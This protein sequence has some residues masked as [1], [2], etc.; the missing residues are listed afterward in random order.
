MA[1][2]DESKPFAPVHY[3]EDD[4]DADDERRDKKT[5]RIDLR[6]AARSLP[7]GRPCLVMV[8]GMQSVGRVV[9]VRDGMTIGR[10]LSCDVVI[11]EQGVSRRHAKLCVAADGSVRVDDLESSNG[12]LCNG[13]K[14]VSQVVRDGDRIQLG[15]A[16]FA[17]LHMDAVDE[18][19]R[20]NLLASASI[21][22]D[23]K[24]LVRRRVLER[25][26]R[27]LSFAHRYGVP[28]AF[29]LFAVDQYKQ[30]ADA[31][32]IHDAHFVLNRLA[33]MLDGVLQREDMIVGRY[34]ED[35]IAVVLPETDENEALT[36][37]EFVRA[38]AEAAVL[39]REREG[40]PL[41]FTVSGGFAVT[42]G[43]D[44]CDIEELVERAENS[45]YRAK[46]AGRNCIG[47]RK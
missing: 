30:L 1:P 41:K 37:A 20:Q 40:E 36:T 33:S 16:A 34:S 3:E 44:A 43:E 15:D 32:G 27:E 18:T 39:K 47:A 25:L 19:L 11:E 22:A 24:L 29:E 45:L 12:I 23:T 31:R 28:L 46:L 35:T 42:T 17:I 14:V 6:T 13:K 26:G 2:D 38:A 9:Q 4:D 21:D 10:A 5:V 8:G 7:K